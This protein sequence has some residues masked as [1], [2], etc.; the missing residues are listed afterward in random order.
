MV[1]PPPKREPNGPPT[2][3]GP[4]DE[5]QPPHMHLASSLKSPVVWIH[6]REGMFYPKVTGE[7]VLR[8]DEITMTRLW[9]AIL[10][11]ERRRFE[12]TPLPELVAEELALESEIR[13]PPGGEQG[14]D[15]LH[16]VVARIRGMRCPGNP[17]ECLVALMIEALARREG[18][19]RLAVVGCSWRP[20]G[21]CEVIMGPEVGLDKPGYGAGDSPSKG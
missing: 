18:R 21:T 16:P 3:L 10:R 1:S 2:T 13:F 4:R 17:R 6:T 8:L 20:N 9:D 15:R 14:H 19:G 7:R 12:G 11:A 5:R